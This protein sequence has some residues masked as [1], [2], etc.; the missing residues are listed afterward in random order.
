MYIFNHIKSL[1]NVSPH[2]YRQNNAHVTL[3]TAVNKQYKIVTQILEIWLIICMNL[4]WT[5]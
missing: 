2:Q 1:L 3:I 5:F 4:N